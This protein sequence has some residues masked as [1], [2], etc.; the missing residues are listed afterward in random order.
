VTPRVDYDQIAHLYDEPIRDH[1]VDQ[2]LLAYLAERPDLDPATAR[3]LDVGCGTGKQLAADRSEL[4][5]ALLVGMDRFVGMLRIAGRRGPGISWV[6]GDGGRL[7]LRSESF[8]FATNQFSY[9]H[10]SERQA[11]VR[12]VYRVLRPGG[13]FVMLNIDPWSMAGW[14]IYQYFPAAFDRDQVDFLPGEAFAESMRE[15][16]FV[17]VRIDRQARRRR[18]DLVAFAE[19]V[20][21]RHR[22]SQLMVISDAEYQAG[23]ARLRQD[24]AAAGGTFAVDSETCLLTI[25]GDRP[26][27]DAG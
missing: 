4:P 1:S 11:F 8:D 6:Q 18:E 14:V 26:S 21:G 5:R 22:T 7:P 16:G 25:S 12:E 15:A 2:R 19:Y 17:H 9:Q 23:L 24:L 20:S 3:V 10:I 27:P 13:R